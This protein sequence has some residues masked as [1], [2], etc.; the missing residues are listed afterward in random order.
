MT[1]SHLLL[2][3]NVHTTHHSG[4]L[5]GILV[6]LDRQRHMEGCTDFILTCHLCSRN[7]SARHLNQYNAVSPLSL[8]TT[9]ISDLSRTQIPIASFENGVG[10]S[11]S[12]ALDCAG[13]S[14]EGNR[15]WRRGYKGRWLEY[16]RRPVP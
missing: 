14:N 2:T 5:G 8:R 6:L 11:L 1:H 4:G 3:Q 7:A 9:S 15:Q 13:V 16:Y 12:G 10:D